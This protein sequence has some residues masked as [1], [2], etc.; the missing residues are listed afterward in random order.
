MYIPIL[1]DLLHLIHTINNLHQFNFYSEK[2][3]KKSVI[4]IKTIFLVRPFDEH[5]EK[6]G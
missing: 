4:N 2:K 5:L 1:I 3:L 6:K